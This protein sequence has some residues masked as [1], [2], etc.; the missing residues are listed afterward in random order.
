M[1]RDENEKVVTKAR[2][3]KPKPEQRKRSSVSSSSSSSPESASPPGSFHEQAI[4]SRLMVRSP[5]LASQ[6]EGIKFFFNH[7]VTDI[8][9]PWGDLNILESTIFPLLCRS[10][11]FANAVSSVGYAGLSNV[12]KDPK[13]MIIAR[14]KYAASL[15]HITRALADVANSDLDTTLKSVVLLAAFEVGPVTLYPTKAL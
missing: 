8:R 12:T 6:D 14:R 3:P 1:F 15:Q 4:V 10:D 13:H 7:Y 2:I 11:S 5:S 9:E